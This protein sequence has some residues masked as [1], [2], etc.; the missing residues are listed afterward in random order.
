LSF[1]APFAVSAEVDSKNQLWLNKVWNY[2]TA[3][4]LKDFDY[5]DNTIKLI[6]MIIVSGNYW[7]PVD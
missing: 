2:T 6:D 7:C 4:K 3:F 1:I 5:Y